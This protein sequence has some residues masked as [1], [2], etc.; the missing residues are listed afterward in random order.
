MATCSCQ[1]GAPNASTA[2]G[3]RHTG[4]R[5]GRAGTFSPAN[6]EAPPSAPVFRRASQLVKFLKI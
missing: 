4:P 3:T 6:A 1:G 2:L 5:A